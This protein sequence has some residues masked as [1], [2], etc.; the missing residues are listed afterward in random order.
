MKKIHKLGIVLAVMLMGAISFN[1]FAAQ[2]GKSSKT[3]ASQGKVVELSSE[4]FKK[5]VADINKNEW[6]YLGDK[7]CI[8]DFYASWC[9]PCKMLSPHLDKMAQKY[10]KDIVVY[11]INVDKNRDLAMAFDARSIPLVVFIPKNGT[12]RANRGYM[13]EAEVETAIQN[14]L[15]NK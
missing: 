14:L 9:G 13:S 8:L 15:L 5:K 1:I 7:P 2:N 11:K 4:D 10:S 12:P 3:S 6:A